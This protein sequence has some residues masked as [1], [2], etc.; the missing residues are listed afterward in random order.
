MSL[1]PTEKMLSK[2]RNFVEAP[3]L[4]ISPDEVKTEMGVPAAWAEMLHQQ[5]IS[6]GKGWVSPWMPYQNLMPGVLGFLQ[7]KVRGVCV[8]LE[9]HKQPSL[10]YVYSHGEENYF[11]RGSI[12]LGSKIPEG[13]QDIW[14]RLPPRLRSFYSQV[15]NGWT[16]LSSNAIGPLPVEDIEFLADYD[17]DL[18]PSDQTRL[19]FQLDKVITVFSNGGGDYLG[20]DLE[21]KPQAV[22]DHALVW[23]H[24]EPLEPDVDQNFWAL[25]DAWI[26]GQMEDVD[27]AD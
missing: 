6:G 16:M 5:N 1:P 26:I 20:L 13:K 18:E 4:L 27:S 17:W 12:A 24:E 10:I 21:Q 2:I 11:H 15:H 22:E 25:M 8:L 3:I 14:E 9:E 19:P 23:W 7:H